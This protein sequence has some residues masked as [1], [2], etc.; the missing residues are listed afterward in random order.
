MG[1]LTRSYYATYEILANL[2]RFVSGGPR[3]L[4][5]RATGRRVATLESPG[6]R[7]DIGA[8]LLDPPGLEA[9]LEDDDAR[10]APS[11]SDGTGDSDAVLLDAYSTAVAAAVDRVAPA[12][13]HLRVE[14]SRR[15]RR[16][17]RRRHRIRFPDHAGWLPPHQQPRGRRCGRRRGDAV[18]RAHR[19]RGGRRRRSGFRPRR[20]QGGRVQS[21]LVQAR[22]LSPPSRRADRHRDRQPVRFPPHGHRGH[23]Q[24]PRPLDACAHGSPPRQHPADGRRAQSGQLRRTARRLRGER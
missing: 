15:G 1:G 20:A 10:S 22:R 9:T 6:C 3:G 18:R 19:E 23:R 8:M 13:A 12:V 17:A 21:S 5:P 2:V 24:R 16:R 11:R 14:G 4:T 7:R